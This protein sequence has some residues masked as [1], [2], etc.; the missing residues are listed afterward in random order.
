M[1]LRFAALATLAAATW[2]VGA[3]FAQDAGPSPGGPRDTVHLRNREVPFS[4]P[5]GRAILQASRQVHQACALD[6]HL[7]CAGKSGGAADRCLAYYRVTFSSPCRKAITGFEREVGPLDPGQSVAPFRPYSRYQTKAQP[8]AAGW[9]SYP[10][11][12]ARTANGA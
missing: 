1:L 3:A 4:A 9:L 6:M 12:E 7:K 2:A 5:P 11:T 10:A 8:P